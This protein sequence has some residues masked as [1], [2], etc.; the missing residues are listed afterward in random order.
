MSKI[1]EKRA[2]ELVMQLM[3]VRGPSCEETEVAAMIVDK[4]RSLGI[5]EAAI[6]FD[7]AHKRTP[8][9]GAIGNLVVKL[10]GTKK[11]PRLMLSAHMDAVPICIGCK[12]K[13]EGDVIKS[14]DPATG[15]GGDDRAGVA[16]VLVGLMEVLESKQDYAP[17]TL[18]FF[19]QEEIGLQ[20]SRNLVVGKLGKP[21]FA[22]NFDG[23]NPRKLTIG[24][25]GGEKLKIKL[26]G[27]PAHAGLSPQNGANAITAASLA[28]ASLHKE[29]W[30][31]LV[32]KKPPGAKAPSTGTS[33][34]GIIHGGNATNVVTDY[35]E[36]D[37]EAR[38]H[39]SPFRTMISNAI[40]EAFIKAAAQVTNSAGVAVRAEVEQRVDY[41]SFRLDEN[42]EPV[43]RAAA[44]VRASTAEEPILAVTDGGVDA[45]WLFKHG[46]PAVTLG[47]G[48]REVHTNKETL[49]VPDFL[50]ACRIAKA[51][52]LG[53]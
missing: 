36:V 2:I 30:L 41:E 28:I 18:C 15:L 40:K 16:A 11:G 34:V 5:P 46:I 43:R 3:A 4:L 37:A 27:I 22:L 26:H 45:N 33:N 32:K 49:D 25:T 12:P 29:G 50:A 48:Q 42:S 10:P 31:G 13:R 14:T 7:S 8:R 52:I 47:C 1:N 21:A 35:V 23:G 9:P 53:G 24:A 6:T 39:E 51:A 20:G 44:T 17:L 38:S 19:V